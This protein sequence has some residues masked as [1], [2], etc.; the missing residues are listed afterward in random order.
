MTAP[1]AWVG[2]LLVLLPA[3]AWAVDISPRS[4][5]GPTASLSGSPAASPPASPSAPPANEQTANGR[6]LLMDANG[7][8]VTN[9]DFPGQFQLLSFG[10]TF[11]P[12]I[13]PTTLSEQAAVMNRLGERAALVQPIFVTVDPERDTA[14]KLRE[15]TTYF[16]PRLIGLTGSPELIAAAARSFGVR[17][18]KVTDPE[19]PPDRYPVDHTAGMFLVGPDGSYIHKFGYGTPIDDITERLAAL[20]GETPNLRIP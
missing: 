10:Y 7:R 15:Y 6:Y 5:A 18:R 16:H 13:C 1:K 4:A 17:Y 19:V 14:E 2:A 11:C 8:A 3:V 12:D 20:L 9:V